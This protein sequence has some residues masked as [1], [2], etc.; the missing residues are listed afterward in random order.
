MSAQKEP[1][2][3]RNHRI[4]KLA[5]ERIVEQVEKMRTHLGIRPWEGEA[6]TPQEAD[7]AFRQIVDDPEAWAELVRAEQQLYH[8]TDER[9]PKRLVREAQSIYARLRR[10]Q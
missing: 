5:A 3:V 10:E 8:L 1:L 9:A 2:N 6:L 4:A 7:E